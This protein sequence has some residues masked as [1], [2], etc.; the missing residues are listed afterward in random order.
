LEPYAIAATALG[1]V[2]LLLTV[3]E[4]VRRKKGLLQYSLWAMLWL[5]VILVGTVPQFYTALLF[6]TQ[7]LGMYTP[8][9]FVTTFSILLIFAT[10]YLLAKRVA[11][12]N[13]KV[14]KVVQ[15]MALNNVGG[16]DNVSDSRRRKE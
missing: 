14:N 5:A 9:H 7:A 8:I 1:A 4:L 10:M 6:A 11:E 16:L 15:H 2:M 13:E 3:R 12:L